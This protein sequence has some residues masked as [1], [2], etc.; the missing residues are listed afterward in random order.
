[1]LHCGCLLAWLVMT[2]VVAAE[3]AAAN[4]K[5][6]KPAM[7]PRTH[8]LIAA[9]QPVRVVL[10]GDSI[11]EVGRS[12]NWHGGA[13]APGANW[14]AVLGQRLGAAYPGVA[15]PVHHFG[16]GGQNSYEGLGRLDGLAAF[17][18][19]LVL[20]AFGANDCAYHFLLPAE[21][22]LALTALATGIRERYG[23]DVVL[24]GTGGDNPLAPFFQHL[25]ETV[26]AQRAAAEAA[27]VPFVDLR[28]AMMAATANGQRWAEYHVNAGNCHP[29]DA[30]HAVWAAA[31]LAVIREALR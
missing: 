11:S 6:A 13:T 28:T 8:Q 23:A 10:Y 22:K 21:T 19:D 25:A 24:V 12:P 2:A 1:M 27:R 5:E 7:L 26:A 16:I 9:R 14:G 31:A 15:F 17:K 20:V 30:G 4:A 18:P 29:T 3:P